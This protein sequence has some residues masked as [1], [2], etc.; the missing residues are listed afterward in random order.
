MF[1]KPIAILLAITF[2]SSL[3]FQACGNKGV[4]PTPLGDN[5]AFTDG[6]L[7]D[8]IAKAA[9]EAQGDKD[10]NG[11]G[12]CDNVAKNDK[13]LGPGCVNEVC[14]DESGEE[15]GKDHPFNWHNRWLWGA[16]G[17]I[18]GVFARDITDDGDLFGIHVPYV[19]D[20][21]DGKKDD[22]DSAKQSKEDHATIQ[23]NKTKL[24]AFG[25][26]DYDKS[27]STITTSREKENDNYVTMLRLKNKATFNY[28]EV[29]GE[30]QGQ[31]AWLCIS[32]KIGIHTNF[33]STNNTEGVGVI[34]LLINNGFTEI[35]EQKNV[36]DEA[37]EKVCQT[38]RTSAFLALQ[39]KEKTGYWMAPV[40]PSY[41]GF[42]ATDVNSIKASNT[43]IVFKDLDVTPTFKSKDLEG[44]YSSPPYIL[45]G[46]KGDDL[47]YCNQDLVCKMTVLMGFSYFGQ[48]TSILAKTFRQ[49]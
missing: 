45:R 1:R 37:L 47:E 2:S 9:C 8:Q 15:K 35:E 12:V 29:L 44:I 13:N 25:E 36:V 16:A 26:P 24:V 31:I 3:I 11:D 22:T 30:R 32:T 23:V 17:I 20:L 41:L 49:Y 46:E 14:K 7:G 38:G 4:E 40:L 10:S 34:Q 19:G 6:T 27:E 39:N 5:N 28:I 33:M 18:M 43:R 48:P 42:K 21:F